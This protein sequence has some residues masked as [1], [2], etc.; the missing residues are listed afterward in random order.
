MASHFLT[1]KDVDRLLRDPSPMA[2]A[3]TAVKV[4]R[5]FDAGELDEK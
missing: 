2:R 4:A 3:A 5:E 1:E